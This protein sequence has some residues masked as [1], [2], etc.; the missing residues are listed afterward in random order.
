LNIRSI[1][2]LALAMLAAR[3]SEATICPSE[4]ARAMVAEGVRPDSENWRDL[5]PA[6]HAAVDLLL[7]QG[8][9]RLSWRGK[10]LSKRGGPYRIGR[11]TIGQ[12][13]ISSASD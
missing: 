4:V 6:V 5:M 8:I 12:D 7:G 1:C 10:L 13:S 11:G 9:I 3:A 2:D